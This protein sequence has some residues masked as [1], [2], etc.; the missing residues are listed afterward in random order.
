MEIFPYLRLESTPSELVA[1]ARALQPL[2]RE[3]AKRWQRQAGKRSGRGKIGGGKLPQ[4]EKAKAREWLAKYLL[5]SPEKEVPR[6]H[7]L[8]VEEETRVDPVAT[9]AAQAR[10]FEPFGTVYLRNGESNA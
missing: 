6:L 9:D 3:A 8:A 2:E 1:I 10:V 4:R 7:Q 5:G